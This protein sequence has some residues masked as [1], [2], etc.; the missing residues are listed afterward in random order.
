[1]LEWSPKNVTF[2]L[3]LLQRDLPGSQWIL[4]KQGLQQDWRFE[5]GARVMD[6]TVLAIIAAFI[7]GPVGV[8]VGAGLGYRLNERATERRDERLA[9]QHNR[10]VRILLHTEIDE[11]LA[12]LGA[13]LHTART[14]PNGI[15]LT[16]LPYEQALQLRRLLIDQPLHLSRMCWESLISSVPAALTPSQVKQTYQFYAE[17]NAISPNREKLAHLLDK[18]LNQRYDEWVAESEL[19]RQ[20][21]HETPFIGTP[22]TQVPRSLG[23]AIDQFAGRNQAEWA[24]YR[25]AI[26]DLLARGN[27]VSPE[28]PEVASPALIRLRRF[29]PWRLL[30]HFGKRN[31]GT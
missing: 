22:G 5:A 26:E 14:G 21:L 10:S 23:D 31:E 25:K 2:W 20:S 24:R 13:Y 6:P 29:P 4:G 1:V 18:L 12:T 27:P 11:N 17:L 15:G 30:T 28:Q 16:G 19:R 8:V 7:S 9:G 3:L